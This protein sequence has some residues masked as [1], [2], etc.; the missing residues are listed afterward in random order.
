MRD[1]ESTRQTNVLQLFQNHVNS[2]NAGRRVIRTAAGQP[3]RHDPLEQKILR[4]QQRYSDALSLLAQQQSAEQERLAQLATIV[5]AHLSQGTSPTKEQHQQIS[6]QLDAHRASS[7]RCASAHSC[8]LSSQ[9]ALKSY[10]ELRQA[11][12]ARF[13]SSTISRE[14]TEHRQALHRLGRLALL[15]LQ[16]SDSPLSEPAVAPLA[17][18]SQTPPTTEQDSSARKHRLLSSTLSWC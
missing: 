9:L 5:H 7:E 16:P 2:I 3:A 18:L 13:S 4:A 14:A 12:D 1:T 10:R 17:S 15:E 11:Y 8:I 6:Q